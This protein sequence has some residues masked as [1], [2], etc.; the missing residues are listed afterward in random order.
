MCRDVDHH[1]VNAERF[2]IFSSAPAFVSL[3][4]FRIF[5]VS[6]LLL[7][8]MLS[9]PCHDLET[10]DGT[11]SST[12][13]EIAG[14]SGNSQLTD[15]WTSGLYMRTHQV[16]ST[17]RY[18]YLIISSIACRLDSNLPSFDLTRHTCLH[19]ATYSATRRGT[20]HRGAGRQ[21]VCCA[22]SRTGL[23]GEDPGLSVQTCIKSI[24][25]YMFYLIY[26]VYQS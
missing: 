23:L 16:P 20:G 18:E 7:L 9:R 10:T 3:S 22:R 17:T 19:A 13:W 8:S 15:A 24:E 11:L 25:L 21:R 1:G 5:Y 6:S 26:V 14:C 2:V 12:G 4:H